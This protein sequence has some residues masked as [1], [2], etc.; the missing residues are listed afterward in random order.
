MDEAKII[1]VQWTKVK[2]QAAMRVVAS[3][4]PNFS[5]GSMFDFDDFTVAAAE[6]YTI[7]SLPEAM[8]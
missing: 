5:I 4:H 7:L 2:Q 8:S 3:G 1:V 6:G